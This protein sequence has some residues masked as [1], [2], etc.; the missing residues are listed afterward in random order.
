[1]SCVTSSFLYSQPYMIHSLSF[2]RCASL[3]VASCIY[4]MVV[5]TGRSAVV[6]IVLTYM[7]R[8][9]ISLSLFSAWLCHNNQFAINSSG[10]NLY[11]LHACIGVC[12]KLF[13]VDVVILFHLLTNYS[14]Q[15]FMVCDDVLYMQSSSGGISPTHAESK[16]LPSVYCCIANLC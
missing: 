1:M 16:V 13:I 4:H 7:L 8:P 6:L 12:I 14:Y 2:C 9:H 11:C 15:Q 3:T 5:N 10:P